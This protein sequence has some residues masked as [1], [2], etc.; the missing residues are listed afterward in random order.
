M[1]KVQ[2]LVGDHVIDFNYRYGAIGIYQSPSLITDAKAYIAP[3]KSSLAGQLSS[4]V[5]EFTVL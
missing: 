1:F 2:S 4:Y 5:F 3:D